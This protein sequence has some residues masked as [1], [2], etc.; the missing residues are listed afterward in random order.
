MNFEE[1]KSGHQ[2]FPRTSRRYIMLLLCITKNLQTNSNRHCNVSLS[3]SLPSILQ[4]RH[5]YP[6]APPNKTACY[7]PLRKILLNCYPYHPIGIHLLSLQKHPRFTHATTQQAL[8]TA[9]K[10]E[11]RR[12]AAAAA[13]RPSELRAFYKAH[14]IS[15]GP[16]ICALQLI[17]TARARSRGRFLRGGDGGGGPRLSETARDRRALI[18]AA[19]ERSPRERRR[20]YCVTLASDRSRFDWQVGTS[21]RARVN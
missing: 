11:A 8:R 1:E 18:D 3:A 16:Y 20:R 2:V 10:Q 7:H 9:R 17:N 12:T 15:A 14:E 13:A 5:A 6:P 4:S 19:R 21:L